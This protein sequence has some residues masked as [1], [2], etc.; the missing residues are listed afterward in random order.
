MF[1]QEKSFLGNDV[2]FDIN[3]VLKKGICARQ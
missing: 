3:L 1:A 2:A